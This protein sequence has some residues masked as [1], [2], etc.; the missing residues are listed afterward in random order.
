MFWFSLV[1]IF[2]SNMLII[3]FFVAQSNIVSMANDALL[4]SQ[5]LLSV[6]TVTRFYAFSLPSLTAQPLHRFGPYCLRSAI[7]YSI[8]SVCWSSKLPCVKSIPLAPGGVVISL[9]MKRPL[10]SSPYSFTSLF[11]LAAWDYAVVR[12]YSGSLLDKSEKNAAEVLWY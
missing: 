11:S 8:R 1:C 6:L 2:I 7:E 4:F 3:K 12:L 9:K 5:E 10:V